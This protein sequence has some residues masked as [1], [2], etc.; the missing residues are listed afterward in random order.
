MTSKLLLFEKARFL[1]LCPLG[2]IRVSL[3]AKEE[4]LGRYE[5]YSLFRRKRPRLSATAAHLLMYYSTGVCKYI[6]S[7]V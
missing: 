7:L 1:S 5:F 4:E 2:L 3:P 6:Y